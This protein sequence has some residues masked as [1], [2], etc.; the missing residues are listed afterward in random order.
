M[1]KY[2]N[3]KINKGFTLVETLMVIFIFALIMGT[4]YSGV[5]A[6]YKTYNYGWQQSQAIEEARRGIETMTKE[7]R[8]ADSGDDGSYPIEKAGDN[9]FIFYSDIRSEEHTSELQSH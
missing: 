2:L 6:L 5:T 3:V 7:I 9:E 1:L 8:E 4:I